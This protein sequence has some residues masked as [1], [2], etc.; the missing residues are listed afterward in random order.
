MQTLSTI[1]HASCVHHPSSLPPS[2]SLFSSDQPWSNLQLH[3]TDLQ[4]TSPS[5]SLLPLDRTIDL[6][7]QSPKLDTNLNNRSG[8]HRSPA[9]STSPLNPPDL[10]AT[11]L[12]PLRSSLSRSISLS[13]NLSLFLVGLSNKKCFYF[14]FWLG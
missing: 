7:T 9:H 5:Q 4:P 13:L 8:H 2:F 3:V 12:D 14:D 10:A 6:V 11:I 1:R